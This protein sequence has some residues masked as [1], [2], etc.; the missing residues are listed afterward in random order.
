MLSRIIVPLLAAAVLVFACGPR[1]PNSAASSRPRASIEQGVT[2][3]VMVD[4]VRGQVRFAIEV[5]NDTRKA[6]EL[7]F[8]DGRTHDFAV[9]DERGREVWRWSTGRLF[10]QGM[11]NRLLEAHDSMVY[12]ERWQPA[13]SGRYTLVAQ[14]HSEN[15]P[16]RQRVEFALP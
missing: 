4:T 1:T 7:N 5:T 12:A 9:I 13:A 15:Y 2:S 10:T 16:V 14:L 3:H 8:P 6:V 11:K